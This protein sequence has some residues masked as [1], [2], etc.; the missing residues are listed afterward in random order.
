MNDVIEYQSQ[1]LPDTLEDLTQFVLV[2]KA[3]LN[4]YMLKLKTVEKLNTAQAIKDQTLKD[5]QEIASALLAAEQRIGELL[6]A[7]PKGS[8]QYAESKNRPMSKNTVA[9]EMGYSKDDVSS[10]QQMAKNPEIVQRVI[11]NAL[12]NGEVPTKSEVTKNIKYEKELKEI[13]EKGSDYLKEQVK[14]GNKTIDQAYTEIK[15]KE[16]KKAELGTRVAIE[17]AQERH[18]EFQ[19]SKT[20][21]VAAVAQDKKDSAT[22]A[23]GLMRE[24][25]NALKQL[26]FIY[27][28]MSGRDKD[29]SMLGKLD[30][31]KK[32]ELDSDISKAT[33]TLRMI[34][35]EMN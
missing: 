33:E 10:Y 17:K 7:I 35:R 6:L 16:R 8:G 20:V 1:Q 31:D 25:Q 14:E 18:E 12:A 29:F 24:V 22:I 9:K 5:S 11:E 23:N 3:R 19:T 4:A 30:P 27:A 34:R 28:A 26:L 21:S 15:N 13:E 2:N 32:R